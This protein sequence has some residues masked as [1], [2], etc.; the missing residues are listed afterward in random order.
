MSKALQRHSA[1]RWSQLLQ[2][3]QRIDAQIKG[4]AQGSPWTSLARL[5]LLMAGQRLAL[6]AE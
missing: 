5:S 2:D 1:Q 3:A 4:Q 6:P